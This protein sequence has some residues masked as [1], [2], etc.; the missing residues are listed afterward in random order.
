MTPFRLLISWPSP[1][2]TKRRHAWCICC[3][4]ISHFYDKDCCLKP[5]CDD[6]GL[7]GTQ[8]WGIIWALIWQPWVKIPQLGWDKNWINMVHQHFLNYLPLFS[9]EREVITTFLPSPSLLLCNSG[10]RMKGT[11]QE[12][13]VFKSA[14]KK[15]VYTICVNMLYI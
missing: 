7:L 11:S 5:V 12:L 9:G 8:T 10:M 6:W 4:V 15:A 1:M 3:G 14:G 13:G 2:L